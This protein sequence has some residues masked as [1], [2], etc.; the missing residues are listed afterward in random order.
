MTLVTFVSMIAAFSGL[1]FVVGSMLVMPLSRTTAQI[2][3][4]LKN[5]RRV[6]RRQ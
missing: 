4:P 5:T 2:T 6:S 1:L 3:G